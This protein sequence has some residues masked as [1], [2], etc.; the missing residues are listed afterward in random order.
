MTAMTHFVI[1]TT[2]DAEPIDRVLTVSA[3]QLVVLLQPPK[4]AL[5]SSNRRRWPC[6]LN[7]P[8]LNRGIISG[9]RGPL[10][11]GRRSGDRREQ[12]SGRTR[13]L[14]SRRLGVSYPRRRSVCRNARR[15]GAHRCAKPRSRS[16]RSTRPPTVPL[17]PWSMR[18]SANIQFHRHDR[19]G[20]ILRGLDDPAFG[21]RNEPARSGHPARPHS[22]YTHASPRRRSC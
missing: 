1:R 19:F 18:C 10:Q 9:Q 17:P 20:K 4:P 6:W 7:S 8:R 16:A 12:S 14:P 22:E 11:G 2:G 13:W 5:R 3:A 21:D 15:S